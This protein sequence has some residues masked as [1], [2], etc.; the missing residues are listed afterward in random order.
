MDAP[1]TKAKRYAETAPR[2]V[3]TLHISSDSDTPNTSAPAGST[4]LCPNRSV[5]RPWTTAISALARM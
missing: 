5:S 3:S 2:S 4:R 1:A